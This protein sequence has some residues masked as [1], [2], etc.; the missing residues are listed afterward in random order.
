MIKEF[1]IGKCYTIKHS[2][3]SEYC[4]IARFKNEIEGVSVLSRNK[5]IY[6]FN[7]QDKAYTS[8]V[9]TPERKAW[10][11]NCI[12]HKKYISEEDFNQVSES[13]HKFKIGDTVKILST[14]SSIGKMYDYKQNY[15]FYSGAV[16]K[17]I[18]KITDIVTFG[19]NANS[20]DPRY[21][22][23]NFN[24][25]GCDLEL[26]IEKP[27]IPNKN[28]TLE[29]RLEYAKKHYPIGTKYYPA[30][31]TKS[32]TIIC[33][34]GDIS[35]SVDSSNDI[36]ESSGNDN[37]NGH[38]YT[39]LIYLY[40][41]DKWAEII[42]N[43]PEP[44]PIDTINESDSTDFK[45]KIGD[46]VNIS[47]IGYTYST[48]FDIFKQ[49]GFKNT[50]VN[51]GI[52]RFKNYDRPWTIFNR[53]KDG[54]TIKYALQSGEFQL[55]IGEKG[56]ELVSTGTISSISNDGKWLDKVNFDIQSQWV[57]DQLK[58]V[59]TKEHIVDYRSESILRTQGNGIWDQINPSNMRN[60][61]IGI[62]PYLPSEGVF[63][64]IAKEL[65]IV[66][67]PKDHLTIPDEPIEI[68]IKRKKK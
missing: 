54:N 37:K 23:N 4:G 33:T 40:D 53:I 57:A 35:L 24:L 2:S 14:G 12:K 19:G 28:S 3:G 25:R 15:T 51:E 59:Y 22:G 10:I 9:E 58:Q 63:T 7:L 13:N 49:L 26:V 56:I 8:V 20:E 60:Y 65:L 1:E 17:D 27:L 50:I 5:S 11:E 45:F 46:I 66:K 18:V 34:V 31:I 55:L 61:T 64:K 6:A 36:K 47:D 41:K 43:S 32:D 62:D 42:T 21:C 38:W 16:K 29:E 30:H 44:K 39:E 52:N 67:N 68:F 48:A